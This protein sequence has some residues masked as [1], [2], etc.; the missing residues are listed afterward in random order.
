MNF[1][2]IILIIIGLALFESI[3]SIDNAVVNADILNTMSKR[4]RRWFLVYGIIAAVFIVRGLLPLFIVYISSPQLGFINAFTATL[5]SNETARH[6]IETNKP[7]LLAGGG[8]YLF[9]LFL[10]WLFIEPKKYAFFIE[11]HIHKHYYFW[12]YS[13]ASVILLSVVWFTIKINPLIALGSVIGSTTFFITNGLK[14]N[15]EE[16]EEELKE[17]KIDDVSKILY[18]E[19]IDAIFSIDGVLG[20]FAFTVSI[21]LIIIGNGLG[22]VIVR[23]FTVHSTEVVK[24]YKYLKNGAM[25]SVGILGL[26][27]LGESL[28]VHIPTWFPPIITFIVVGTFFWLSKKELEIK[29]AIKF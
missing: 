23:Y 25:Y 18:L 7:I 27:M 29:G 26:I 12:F 4:A 10:Y 13:F 1:S 15:A 24:R 3:S 20:A 17:K 14:K 22:A 21:P 9:F 5:G 19:L 6:I 16:K 11:S 2:D 8:I 28:S